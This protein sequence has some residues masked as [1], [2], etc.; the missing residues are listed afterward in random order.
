MKRNIMMRIASILLV[1]V[2]MTTG[3]VSGTFAKYTSQATASDSA[4][5]AKWAFKVGT[6]DIA[7]TKNFSFDLFT[8]I[9]DTNNT[10]DE[11]DVVNEKIAP[12]T[13]GSFQ[14]S[15]QNI[16]EVT[17]KYTITLAQ[18]QTSSAVVPIEYS[19][20]PN[21]TDWYSASNFSTTANVGINATA[22][23][24]I[25]WRW[26]INSENTTDTTIGLGTGSAGFKMT[27]TATVTAEQVD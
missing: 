3:A 11:T 18:T 14:F 27:V 13:A 8:T 22:T 5:V 23:P 7:T 6:T 4:T 2:L 12:G 9:N 25:Y 20:D 1:A 26:A 15:L 19:T 16:S 21:Q 10:A 24:T 17:A